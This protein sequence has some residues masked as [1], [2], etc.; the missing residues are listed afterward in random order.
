MNG[1]DKESKEESKK[2]IWSRRDFLTCLG[3]GGFKEMDQGNKLD[4]TKAFRIGVV[5]LIVGLFL[6]GFLHAV[7]GSSSNMPFEKWYGNWP[8][9]VISTS[10]ILMSF[11]FLT[12]PR[13]PREWQGAG[14]ATAF[15][16]SLFTEMFGI[17]LT[18]YLLAPLLDIE[19]QM[20]GANES[21]LW[22]YLLSRTGVMNLE[23]GVYFVMVVS[24]GL[25]VIGFYLLGMG[26]K[27]V[28][29]GQGAL[30]TDELYA[31]MRHPQYV[32]LILIVVGF[33]IMWPTLPTLLLAPLL[34]ARYILVAREE[35]KE[36]EE[37]F[38]DDFSRYKKR[39]PAFI[40]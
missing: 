20:F 7:T 37:K 24:S 5:I 32:G 21:H 17:P 34:V 30:V 40:P 31:K 38:G 11:F 15:F 13:R 19:P 4:I 18:I 33:L 12:R 3:W 14:L 9:V 27:E 28:Y 26:W 1:Q 36:L 25:T 23:V 39:V 29:G 16:I 2:G 22:A 10:V 8:T 35:D 6:L